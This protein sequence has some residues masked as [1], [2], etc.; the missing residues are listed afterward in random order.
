MTMRNLLFSLACVALLSASFALADE[1]ARFDG[2]EA[3]DSNRLSHVHRAPEADFRRY[4]QV[5]I[6]DVTVDFARGWE[7]RVRQSG[8]LLRGEDVDRIRADVAA[9]VRES[10]AEHLRSRGYEVVPALADAGPDA[11]RV[12]PRLV[13]VDVYPTDVGN[14]RFSVVR[15]RSIGELTLDIDYRDAASGALLASVQD[16]K[17][18]RWPGAPVTRNQAT[19]DSRLQR[20]VEQWAE[21][22]DAELLL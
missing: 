1:A 19:F 6:D 2:L 15:G 5:V 9:V 14:N 4:R 12:S 17:L 3:V 10:Y 11:L 8:Y 18:D 16:R 22:L 7:R 13:D 20:I 21:A